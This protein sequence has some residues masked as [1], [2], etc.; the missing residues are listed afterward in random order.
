MCTR[1]CDCRGVGARYSAL[2]EERAEEDDEIVVAAA[3]E[4]N[5]VVEVTIDSGPVGMFGR[6]PA[7]RPGR[8][9]RWK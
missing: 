7:R 9:R 8:W 2:Q 4:A 5:E 3:E 6:S 1:S